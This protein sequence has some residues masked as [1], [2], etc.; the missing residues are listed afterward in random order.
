MELRTLISTTRGNGTT[1]L[2]KL[3]PYLKREC[4]HLG[5]SDADKGLDYFY[6]QCVQAG[7]LKC[8]LYERNPKA[9]A[10]RV[11][12]IFD[13]LKR[14]PIPV[15]TGDGPGDYGV[16]DYAQVRRTVFDFVT[17]PFGFGGQSFANILAALEKADGVPF[18]EAHIDNLNYQQC[19]SD[20]NIRQDSAGFGQ[21]GTLAIG[22]SDGDP[23]NDTIPQLQKWYEAN[24]KQSSFAELWPYRVLCA[25]VIMHT[26]LICPCLTRTNRGWRI[27]PAE[28]LRG[29][30]HATNTSFPLL[31][32]GNTA[33]PVA[34]LAFAKKMSNLFKGSVLL[35]V[36]TPGVSVLCHIPSASR[37][38]GVI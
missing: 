12:R 26:T 15:M 24:Q 30:F 1:I 38:N 18:Y 20:E 25:Y 11:E 33:D 35:T 4:A 10:T 23:A 31:L 17:S 13:S 5:I 27:R 28:K 3:S 29:P 36:D 8:A 9:V 7:Q 34:P 14:Q 37:V 6:E 21:L 22:C 32:I 2:C 16:V 19:Q